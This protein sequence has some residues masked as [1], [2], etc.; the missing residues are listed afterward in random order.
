MG[1]LPYGANRAG[2]RYWSGD[3]WLDG[4]Y[5]DYQGPL[6]RQP[7][8]R[9]PAGGGNAGGAGEPA[10]DSKRPEGHPR[11]AKEAQRELE[12]EVTAN[13]L[14]IARLVREIREQLQANALA[15]AADA[16]D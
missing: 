16:H 5:S 11:S 14:E 9:E 4:S 1:D 7:A 10:R 8:H 2:D 12:A 15:A 6:E 3:S 13:S